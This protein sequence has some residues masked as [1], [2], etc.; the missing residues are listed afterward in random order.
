MLAVDLLCEIDGLKPLLVEKYD[1]LT[2]MGAVQLPT[3]TNTD[4]M[5]S[6]LYDMTSIEVVVHRYAGIPILRLSV[7]AH[8][9]KNDILLLVEGVKAYY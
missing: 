9:S 2:L 7:H 5:K 3:D 6:W 1:P 4:H 8:V